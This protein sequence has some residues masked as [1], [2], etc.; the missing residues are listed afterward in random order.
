M[1]WAIVKAT[2]CEIIGSRHIPYYTD[3][4]V[5]EYG[6]PG[7]AYP[8]PDTDDGG[9][10]ATRLDNGVGVIVYPQNMKKIDTLPN[11]LFSRKFHM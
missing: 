9:Y 6:R 1:N 11:Q 3:T 10:Y 4:Y 5:V 2:T 7:V 8:S